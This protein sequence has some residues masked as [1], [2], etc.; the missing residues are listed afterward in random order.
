MSGSGLGFQARVTW[1]GPGVAL[2]PVGV[3][4]GFDWAREFWIKI[5]PQKP[6][7]TRDITSN[8]RQNQQR[9]ALIATENL[10]FLG[11]DFS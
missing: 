8:L 1:P 3:E 5:F 4:G 2:S 11:H 7:K 6:N 9:Q 10:P